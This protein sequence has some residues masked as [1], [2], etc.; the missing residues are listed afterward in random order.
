MKRYSTLVILAALSFLSCGFDWGFGIQDKCSKAKKI[1]GGLAEIKEEDARREAESQITK[2]CPDGA[3]EHFIRAVNLERGGNLEGALIEYRSALKDDPE[4]GLAS[5]NLGL[6]YLQKGL[7]DDAVVEL[8]KAIKTSPGPT[9]N[10]ALG[11]IF[12][13]KKL[14]SLALYHY[15]EAIAALPAE[16]SLHNDLARVY[17][18]MGLMN[19]AEEEYTRVLAVEP[20]NQAARLGLAALFSSGNQ[21]DK[22]I[23]ELKKAQL[24]DPGNKDIH[25][26][27]AEA[28]DKRGDKKT[29]SMNISL[30]VSLSKAKPPLNLRLII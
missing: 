21:L 9:Y 23:S 25:R 6:I 22:A 26:Q 16:T 24:G 27:L 2:L 12:G 4:F 7:P 14:Y 3:A 8:T 5:G 13:D 11:R 28:Y 17:A 18:D 15:N 19:K 30:P 10:K 29:P 1:A 20:G